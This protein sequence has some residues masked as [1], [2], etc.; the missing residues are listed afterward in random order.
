M[1]GLLSSLLFQVF[2][3]FEQGFCREQS[4]SRDQ[5]SDEIS[6]ELAADSI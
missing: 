6:P 3:G 1:P 4:L 5:I 2:S